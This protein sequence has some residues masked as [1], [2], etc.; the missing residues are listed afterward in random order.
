[1]V[2]G[3]RNADYCE[4]RTKHENTL[5]GQ[6]AVFQYVKAGG[7]SGNFWAFEG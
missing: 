3:E 5:C 7:I 4:N 6:N 1:M 2:V